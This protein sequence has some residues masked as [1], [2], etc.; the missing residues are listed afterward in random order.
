MVLVEYYYQLSVGYFLEECQV[1]EML[2]LG[3]AAVNKGHVDHMVG[4]VVHLE[5]YEQ[6]DD[7]LDDQLDIAD[8]DGNKVGNDVDYVLYMADLI[9]E[10]AEV[11]S[12]GGKVEDAEL[13]T[14]DSLSLQ[15]GRLFDLGDY[16]FGSV[17]LHVFGYFFESYQLN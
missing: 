6:L 14:A 4:F 1:L 9:A 2:V 17:I 13:L 12:S 11:V 5:D 10:M 15:L 8:S 3:L 7:Q 16:E